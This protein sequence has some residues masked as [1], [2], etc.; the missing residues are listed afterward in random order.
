MV[1]YGDHDSLCY[2]SEVYEILLRVEDS[3]NMPSDSEEE[4]END[5]NQKKNNR[6]K[7]QSSQGPRKTQ[8]LKRSGTSSSFSSGGLSATAPRRGG[9]FLGGSRFQR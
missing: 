8:S 9:R 7:G 3:E 5:G 6:D 2:L 1:F 4:E